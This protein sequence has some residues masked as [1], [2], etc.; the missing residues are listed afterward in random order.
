M[1]T[2]DPNDTIYTKDARI[3]ANLKTNIEV[4]LL[5]LKV[6]LGKHG[7]SFW[8]SL[9]LCNAMQELTELHK[10][11]AKCCDHLS[12]EVKANLALV[13]SGQ[14]STGDD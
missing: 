2:P 14:I 5:T 13:M 4:L 7:H 1:K 8:C 12:D 6:D 3:L 10:T 9:A 11:V